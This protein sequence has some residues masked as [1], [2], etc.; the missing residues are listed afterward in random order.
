MWVVINGKEHLKYNNFDD[1]VSK[2]NELVES[3]P[4]N[5]VKLLRDDEYVDSGNYKR[6]RGKKS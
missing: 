2:L 4:D 6:K 5:V 3:N 1:A